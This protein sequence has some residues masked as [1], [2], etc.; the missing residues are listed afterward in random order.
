MET[1][2]KEQKTDRL[3]A[4]VFI[5]FTVAS[6]FCR[7]FYGWDQDE[8]Y[9]ILLAQRIADG[10]IIFK[11]MWDL[12]Q[13][14]AI[15][16]SVFCRAYVGI[17]H[18]TDG[19]AV[20]LRGM[21][22]ILQIIVAV[23]TFFVVRRFYGDKCAFCAGVVVANLLPRA[24]QE[25]EY[26]TVAVWGCLICSLLFFEMKRRGVNYGKIIIAAIFYAAAVYSYPTLIITVP[27]VALVL[28]I[29]ISDKRAEGFK[30][31]LVFFGV[32][33]VCAGIL[34]AYLFSHMTVEEFL[35]IVGEL[36]KNDDHLVYFKGFWPV[37][38]YK[39]VIRIV[40]MI[41]ISAIVKFAMKRMFKVDTQ[42]IN[43]FFILTTLFV[44]ILNL[45][46]IRPSGPF[47]LLERYIGAVIL[48]AFS[49]IEKE[50]RDFTLILGGMGIFVFLGVIMG[51][52]LGMNENAMFLELSMICMVV[53]CVKKLEGLKA[54][55][56]FIGRTAIVVFILGIAFSTG[57]FVRID[58]TKPANIF[59]CTAVME[60]GPMKGIGVFP[61]Q[62]ERYDALAASAASITESGRLYTLLTND[63]ITY[64]FVNGDYISA[65]YAATA[66]YYNEQ[67]VDFYTKFDRKLPDEMLVNKYN[68]PELSELEKTV[69]GKWV[70]TE[71]VL[72]SQKSDDS[73]WVFGLSN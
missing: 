15:F 63:A 52:N 13:T 32:C 69:F 42:I 7:L 14:A 64:Y 73:F 54:K 44:V 17:F 67:W 68:Y 48:A 38:A 66:Q 16:P 60:K 37:Y 9:N 71:Y 58:S 45:I 43:V 12:H 50:D 20:F 53:L 41:A 61:E 62:K 4:L 47:G 19:I 27:F 23:Y 70:M 25:T 3:L 24:T 26:S 29:V 5:V 36:G 56:L 51:S 46:G 22:V 34:F 10:K 35:K 31:A 33:L 18:T 1:V 72:D 11:D 55:E 40:A 2:S 6:I 49:G 65:Q 21:S 28:I 39:S 30:I 57:Y 8:S 59:Q